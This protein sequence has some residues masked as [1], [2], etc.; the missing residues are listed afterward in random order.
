MLRSKRLGV[1][2]EVPYVPQY[3]LSEAE[4]KKKHTQRQKENNSHRLGRG[5]SARQ[6]L[7]NKGNSSVKSLRILERR[8]LNSSSSSRRDLGDVYKRLDYDSSKSHVSRTTK[9]L[10]SLGGEKRQIYEFRN[11]NTLFNSQVEGIEEYHSAISSHTGKN[12]F[13]G[14]ASI[15]SATYASSN[16]DT[17]NS[18]IT[19]DFPP[20]I[21]SSPEWVGALLMGWSEKDRSKR[22]N[23][24]RP[25]ASDDY[26]KFVD[27]ESKFLDH[28]EREKSI[29]LHSFKDYESMT[30]QMKSQSIPVPNNCTAFARNNDRTKK[31]LAKN[32]RASWNPVNNAVPDGHP[33]SQP[34]LSK[35]QFDLN[36]SMLPSVAPHSSPF[37]NAIGHKKVS[38]AHCVDGLGA[39]GDW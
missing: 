7:P 38:F 31:T 27:I 24:G 20:D 6:Q 26:K 14:T 3:P 37:K 2:E 15:S 5:S 4:I 36:P 10:Q 21:H 34:Y 12:T 19:R 35:R 16:D 32:A 8:P 11:R 18:V 9:L 33:K 13:D 1:E 29:I 23:V 22:W 25:Q 17:Y 28:G 30:N 39:P